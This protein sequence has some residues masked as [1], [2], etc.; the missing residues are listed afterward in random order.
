MEEKSKHKKVLSTIALVVL[1]AGLGVGVY[2]V[3][4]QQLLG[5]RA[6]IDITKAFEIKD[7]SGNALNCSNNV[8]ET[9]TLDVTI[10]L[11][12]INALTQ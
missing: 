11:K 3:G 6:E 10:E 9:E 1:L 12:D 7:A 2:L 5:T 4:Q 8:C